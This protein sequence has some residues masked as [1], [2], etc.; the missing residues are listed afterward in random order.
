MA[1]AEPLETTDMSPRQSAKETALCGAVVLAVWF[2]AWLA[3]F[4]S[5]VVQT[6]A[7]LPVEDRRTALLI[8]DAERAGVP[9]PTAIYNATVV[10]DMAPATEPETGIATDTTA[11]PD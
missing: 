4:G 2:S 7:A 6:T 10:N 5:A 8:A 9:R 1:P 11:A 3:G